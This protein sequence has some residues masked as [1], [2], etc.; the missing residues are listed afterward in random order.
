MVAR[1]ARVAAERPDGVAV[2]SPDGGLSYGELWLRALGVAAQL[3][4]AGVRR[5]DPV[6]LCVP[7]SAGFVVGAVGI[8]ASGACYVPLDPSYPT[9]RLSFMLVD[10]GARA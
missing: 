9:D 8:L 2:A 5:G 10:S 7:R 6:A 3:R 1:I 4:K